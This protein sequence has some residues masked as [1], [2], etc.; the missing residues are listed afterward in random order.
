MNQFGK[1]GRTSDKTPRKRESFFGRL[2]FS[3]SANRERMARLERLGNFGGTDRADSV[4][5]AREQIIAD[6]VAHSSEL[7]ELRNQIGS[8]KE[9]IQEEAPDNSRNLMSG[10]ATGDTGQDL[11]EK[12]RR[13]IA[14]YKEDET[15]E[16]S[17]AEEKNDDNLS[18]LRGELTGLIG[19]TP[20]GAPV[21][22]TKPLVYSSKASGEEPYLKDEPVVVGRRAGSTPTRS[23]SKTS[24]KAQSAQA[25]QAEAAIVAQRIERNVAAKTSR[26]QE[27]NEKQDQTSAFDQSAV[28][29]LLGELKADMSALKGE[30]DKPLVPEVDEILSLFAELKAD[31][32]AL[33]EERDQPLVPEVD[34]ILGLFAELKADM[35]A[36]KEERAQ[37]LAADGGELYE[38]V[39]ELKR[40]IKSLK[41]QKSN[42]SGYDDSALVAAISEL[43]NEVAELAGAKS[44]QGTQNDD[45][46]LEMFSDLQGEFSSLR[47]QQSA[48]IEVSANTDVGELQTMLADLKG[49]LESLK[50]EQMKAVE[51]AQKV[52]AKEFVGIVQGL[53]AEF[54]EPKNA[55]ADVQI[56][57]AKAESASERIND[58]LIELKG[59]VDTARSDEGD[60]G[61][62]DI[63]RLSA[64][65]SVL[66]LLISESGS[67]KEEKS[68]RAAG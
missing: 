28:L 60:D 45:V 10:I 6:S 9:E 41:K 12:L 44:E 42:A 62:V 22:K 1:R 15:V 11:L 29:G 68:K 34:E 67:N 64:V 31:M 17:A 51:Q 23:A 14:C 65:N 5:Q 58:L 55:Q 7:R 49:E 40:E 32:T 35:K 57:A 66:A 53:K 48:L 43:K 54:S 4:L 25:A 30:Q 39:A 27:R 61:S 18:S 38:L 21:L 46:L 2:S 20:E 59:E 56:Y 16:E 33:K 13:D 24:K 47:K 52:Q 26:N 3:G 50:D 63:D 36:L 8:W 37:P 19:G